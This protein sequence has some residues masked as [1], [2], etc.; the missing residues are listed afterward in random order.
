VTTAV[1]ALA[2]GKLYVGPYLLIGA[3]PIAGPGNYYLPLIFQLVLAMPLVV[4]SWRRSPV[5][6]AIGLVCL[7]LAFEVGASRVPAL[8][9]GGSRLF[10]YDC[11]AFRYLGAVAIGVWLAS[12]AA[13][14]PVAIA[15][16]A[17]G[18]VAGVAY[19]GL[20]HQHP[21]ERFLLWEPGFERRTNV[22]TVCLAG[23]F[24][25]AGLRW[26]PARPRWPGR[27]VAHLG[28]ASYHIFL[29]QVL[30]FGLFP[31]ASVGRFV[32]GLVACAIIGSLFARLLPGGRP[33]RAGR[34]V[35][36]HPS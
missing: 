8:S 29:V 25:T 28:S 3:L 21:F 7:D 14:R 12:R 11:A 32:V 36:A 23:I 17:V 26:L 4:W 30:W 1:L 6:T 10:L 24:V 9:P 33:A 18:A 20:E 2:A 22:L 16:L 15:W 34:T 13:G 19:L 35:A 5:A 27:M 31:G